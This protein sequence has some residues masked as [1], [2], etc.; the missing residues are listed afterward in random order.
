MFSRKAILLALWAAACGSVPAL[1]TLDPVVKPAINRV[2]ERPQYVTPNN[3]APFNPQPI[4]ADPKHA[5]KYEDGR[6]CKGAA[7]DLVVSPYVSSPACGYGD[8][9]VGFWAR[10]PVRRWVSAPFRIFRR[11]RRC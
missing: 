9:S 1:A 8:G 10:G 5:M 2:P 11:W 7:C 6:E 4:K 3:P